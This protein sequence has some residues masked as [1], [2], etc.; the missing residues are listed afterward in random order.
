[1]PAVIIP[2]PIKSL[3]PRGDRSELERL[4]DLLDAADAPTEHYE[5][6][7]DEASDDGEVGTWPEWHARST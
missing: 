7:T 6:E 2:F 4:I 1:M 3:L 5:P